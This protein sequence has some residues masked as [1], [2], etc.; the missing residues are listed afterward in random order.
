MQVFE[1]SKAA[2]YPSGQGSHWVDSLKIDLKRPGGHFEQIACP[3]SDHVPG[4]HVTHADAVVDP[5]LAFTVP[6]AHALH[7]ARPVADQ[8]PGLQTETQSASDLDPDGEDMPFGHWRQS[9]KLVDPGIGLYVPEGHDSQADTTWE[10]TL[11][12]QVPAGQA[13]QVPCPLELE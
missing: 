9:F 8:D 1:P 3:F 7:G 12:L 4:P 13:E 2:K 10:P 5:L 11:L 6:A